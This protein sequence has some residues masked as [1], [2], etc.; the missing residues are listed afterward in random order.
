MSYFWKFYDIR[1]DSLVDMLARSAKGTVGPTQFCQHFQ[2]YLA[3]LARAHMFAL[4]LLRI[5]V[6]FKYLVLNWNHTLLFRSFVAKKRKILTRT[7]I[8]RH[9]LHHILVPTLFPFLRKKRNIVGILRSEIADER[10]K[11]DFCCLVEEPERKWTC[12]GD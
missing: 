7:R 11:S 1:G 12:L 2:I 10:K 6:I 3:W 9:L 5:R 8:S 4:M